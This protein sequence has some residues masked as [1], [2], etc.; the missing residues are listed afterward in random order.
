MLIARVKT[1]LSPVKYMS[2]VNVIITGMSALVGLVNARLLGPD[3]LGVIGVIL[4]IYATITTFIDVRLVDVVAK[5]YYQKEEVN[6]RGNVLRVYLIYSAILG[7]IIW[8]ISFLLVSRVGGYFT[9]V[10]I[11]LKWIIY[12]S[13]YFSLNYWSSAVQYQQRFSERFYLIGTWR[14]VSYLVWA[15]VFLIIL[16]RRPNID[17]YFLA[18][19]FGGIVNAVIAMGL[20]VFIWVRYEKFDVFSFRFSGVFKEYFRYIRLVFWGNIFGYAKLLHRGSD[21]LLVGYFADDR[22]TGLYKIAR[23]LADAT[24]VFYDSINQVYF[25]RFM[26]MLSSNSIQEYRKLVI[27]VLSTAGGLTFVLML[28]EWVG[29]KYFVQFV[30][31]TKFQGAELAIVILTSTLFFIL[32]FHIWLWPIF[33]H[34]GRLR[35]F[36]GY[37]ILAGAV[38]YLVIFV[39]FRIWQPDPALASFGYLAYYLIL[40][41]AM[42]FL[43]RDIE[44]RIVQGINFNR[45]YMN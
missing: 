4:G 22:V 28:G 1:L 10:P 18:S 25:P 45:R 23:S 41:P 27:R 15:A 19:F 8:V 20:S 40:T 43:A 42:W 26:Q 3:S 21:I 30:L 35:Q 16:V 37:S 5:L 17:G 29:L 44:P 32:G 39:L 12:S 13:F 2:V 9:D 24:F 36:T 14:F 31:T 7:L 38:Q 11:K 6:Y 33:I 34:S